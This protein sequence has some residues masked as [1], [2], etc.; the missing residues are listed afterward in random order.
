[1]G[2][3]GRL[4]GPYLDDNIYV[5]VTDRTNVHNETGNMNNKSVY[6]MSFLLTNNQEI[7][8]I[9]LAHD[10]HSRLLSQRIGVKNSL[11][12]SI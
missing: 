1:L 11:I 5:V 2:R 4:A 10:K 12:T 8:M 9:K 3:H 6:L 7:C